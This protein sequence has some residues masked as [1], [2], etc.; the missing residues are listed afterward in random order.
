MVEWPHDFFLANREQEKKEKRKKK[1][2]FETAKDFMNR[3]LVV[4]ES[5][6]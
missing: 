5:G 2:G 3:I 4:I 6:V 1:K